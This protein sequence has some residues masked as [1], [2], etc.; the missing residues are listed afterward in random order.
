MESDDELDYDDGYNDEH[1]DEQDDG[2]DGMEYGNDPYEDWDPYEDDDD[3]LDPLQAAPDHLSAV[4]NLAMLYS[5]L[6]FGED[7]P[8]TKQIVQELRRQDEPVAQL[9]ASF[10]ELGSQKTAA[11][12]SLIASYPGTWNQ[13]GP[14]VQLIDSADASQDQQRHQWRRVEHLATIS[15]KSHRPQ[16]DFGQL[17]CLTLKANELHDDCLA[18]L[19]LYIQQA[20]SLQ[21]LSLVGNELGSDPV[22]FGA[23]GRSVAHSGIRSLNLSTNPIQ[24]RSLASLLSSL[25][26]EASCLEVLILRDVQ[27][28]GKPWKSESWRLG[29]EMLA[30]ARAIADLISVDSKCRRL[31]SF[32][33]GR[34][35]LDQEALRLIIAAWVGSVWALRE[36]LSLSELKTLAAVEGERDWDQLVARTERR[37]N[38]RLTVLDLD[39]RVPR[40]GGEINKRDLPKGTLQGFLRQGSPDRRR[41]VIRYLRR[42]YGKG[43]GVALPNPESTAT[44]AE[45]VSDAR[46]CEAEQHS[47]DGDDAAALTF[48]AEAGGDPTAWGEEFAYVLAVDSGVHLVDYDSITL[49]ME[50][51]T[52]IDKADFRKAAL[53]VVKAARVLGCRARQR[54]ASE[55]GH[56]TPSLARFW[57][58]PPELQ[59]LV[60][61]NLD[62][63]GVLSERQFLEVVSFAQEPSTIGYGRADFDWTKVLEHSPY[64]SAP[65]APAMA[66]AAAAPRSR[67]PAQQEGGAPCRLPCH[68]WSWDDCF[69]HRCRALD[70][71]TVDL[72]PCSYDLPG[73]GPDLVAFWR[74]TC[75]DSPDP[76]AKFVGEALGPVTEADLLEG[77]AKEMAEAS[78]GPWPFADR[79]GWD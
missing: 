56:G 79:D 28:R 10:L 5:R 77:H 63:E 46:S 31:R 6:D 44:Q 47:D 25:Q 48:I 42:Q 78:R 66:Q 68:R 67:S 22:A 32:E 12:L 62:S 34:N 13:S 23:F 72:H 30:A 4:R 71:P 69:K 70:W 40:L 75:T 45:A 33:F 2:F 55:I 27:S 7:V 8:S 16:P 57:S 74:A 15:V 36:E 53:Y 14:S 59:L 39:V 37:P 21:T 61:R 20:H 51:V 54:P 50:T 3:D 65:S 52:S 29:D 26:H 24:P 49:A 58:L 41:H 73:A 17:R 1:D 60:V 76:L 64:A 9:D 11:L 18:P 38:R 19:S 35:D 43:L